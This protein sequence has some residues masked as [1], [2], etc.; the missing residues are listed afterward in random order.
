MRG[1]PALGTPIGRIFRVPLGLIL[2]EP[3]RQ[4]E[5]GTI[6]VRHVRIMTNGCR[7]SPKHRIWVPGAVQRCVPT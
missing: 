3:Y 2:F 5:R 6:T 1:W 7:R 4:E